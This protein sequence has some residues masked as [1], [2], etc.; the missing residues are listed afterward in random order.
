[1]T[2][3]S[4]AAAEAPS[5]QRHCAG[6]STALTVAPVK[7]PQALSSLFKGC[8]DSPEHCPSSPTASLHPAKPRLAL[9]LGAQI[10]RTSSRSSSAFLSPHSAKRQK[11][12]TTEE[13]CNTTL[14]LLALKAPRTKSLCPEWHLLAARPAEVLPW[15]NLLT[16]RPLP[17]K[18]LSR[19]EIAIA[20]L[21]FV[22]YAI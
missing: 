14:A 18:G 1:M 3:G 13:I 4:L 7:H 5:A 22:K 12:H 2:D 8:Q 16:C 15:E 11:N 6:L 21:F 9:L 10:R 17:P 19:M 20:L